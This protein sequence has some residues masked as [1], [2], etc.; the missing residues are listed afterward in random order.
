MGYTG[1][2]ASV[3]G[4]PRLATKGAATRRP[5]RCHQ[6]AI[7]KRNAIGLFAV[8]PDFT[9]E[10]GS[11]AWLQLV[12]PWAT[13][14]RRPPAASCRSESSDPPAAAVT[15]GSSG[16]GPRSSATAATKSVTLMGLLWYPSNPAAMIFCRS[17]LITD[18][19]MA[20]TGSPALS[21]HCGSPVGRHGARRDS[22]GLKLLRPRLLP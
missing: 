20:R 6:V 16:R 12:T 19:V 22:Y 14:S 5:H 10:F 21:R 18:A 9:Q 7:S 15:A 3:A 8:P 17:S 4:R 13:Q 1:R 2:P 11:P